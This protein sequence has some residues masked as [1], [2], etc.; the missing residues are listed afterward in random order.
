M[1][2]YIP[3]IIL[4][5]LVI[6]C[7]GENIPQ[8]NQDAS[9][10]TAPAGVPQFDISASFNIRLND[11]PLA[12]TDSKE[13]PVVSVPHAKETDTL[14]IQYTAAVPCEECRL[15]TQIWCDAKYKDLVRDT[16]YGTGHWTAIPVSRLHFDTAENGSQNVAL[17]LSV[18]QYH[19]V[20][21]G[22]KRF[23]FNVKLALDK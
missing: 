17:Y 15:E 18:R 7:G 9:K 3:F 2:K 12:L 6:G 10:D 11:Q 13:G 14:F 20:E 8:Q 4:F 1:S 19:P 16:G 23:L 5:L 21:T 22:N